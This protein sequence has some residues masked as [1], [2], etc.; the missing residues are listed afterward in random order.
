M[1]EYLMQRI[2]AIITKL[3]EMLKNDDNTAPVENYD[4]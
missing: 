2:R 4:N 3:E 1:M